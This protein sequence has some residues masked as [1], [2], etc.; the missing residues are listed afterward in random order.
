MSKSIEH[1]LSGQNPNASEAVASQS[2]CTV[3]GQTVHTTTTTRESTLNTASEKDLTTLEPDRYTLTYRAAEARQVMGWIKAGQSGC[4]VG[5][6]G[7]GKSNFLRFLLR[8]DVQQHYLGQNYANFALVLI[9]LLALTER[10]EWAICELMLDRLSAQLCS[11]VIEPETIEEMVSLDQNVTRARDS[12]TAR[13]AVEQCMD[14]LCQRPA[15]RVVL[16]FDEFDAVF[17]TLD[18]FLF[19]CLRAIRDAHK[20]QISYIVVA[21]DDLI[22]QRGDLPEVE[23]FCRLVSRNV[24]G[25]GPYSEP[26]ARQ[27]I[28]H[29]ASQRPTELRAKDTARLVELSGGHAGLIKAA[30]SWFW[31]MHHEGSLADIASALKDE[32]GVQVECGKLW[33]SL[34][35][36]EQV[37]LRALMSRTQPDSQSLH[38]LQRKGLVR[39]DRSIFSPLF[40]GFVLKCPPSESE[41]SLTVLWGQ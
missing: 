10:T 13:Q 27:M 15:Q 37:A 25:L 11:P 32:P 39:K 24:C 30:L 3:P 21:A 35:Q 31:N 4:L 12:L 14:V 16:L 38:R 29:L 17:R 20:D 19:R 7:A 9:D 26:D 5:L 6:R 1:T 41:W 36:G 28:H 18:P 40:S 33:D 22:G 2:V 8:Q 23:H 34:S